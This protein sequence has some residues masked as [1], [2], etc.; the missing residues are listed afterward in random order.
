MGL[1]GAGL[2]LAPSAL[3]QVQDDAALANV[4]DDKPTG[5][6][7]TTSPS[8]PSPPPPAVDEQDQEPP[9]TTAELLRAYPDL[10]LHATPVNH[11]SVLTGTIYPFQ[12]FGVGLGSD[13]YFSRVHVSAVATLGGALVVND[14]WAASYYGEFSV[15]V[16]VLR[17]VGPTAAGLPLRPHEYH[18]PPRTP[19]GRALL[20]DDR[21][22]PLTRALVPSSHS[23]E[24]EAGLFSGHYSLYRCTANCNQ[25]PRLGTRELQDAS[26]Q[27]TFVYA[28]LRYV[29]F[30]W[31][32]SEEAH[33]RAYNGIQLALDAITNPSTPHDATVFNSYDAHPSYTPIGFR[34]TIDIPAIRCEA[35][36]RLCLGLNLMGGYLPSPA[37]GTFMA[38][39]V[40][41]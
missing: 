14:R 13:L 39:L 9:M 30:R 33:F 21:V 18:A 23:L 34:T 41:R 31:A 37:D 35:Q 32:Y 19:V 27:T 16:A 38:G 5:T 15:G 8:N 36:G 28:G 25:D 6:S 12:V 10:Q 7:E 11:L 24:V 20:G 22:Q 3:A 1:L 29:Y 40:L 2:T 17:W 4:P 26:L